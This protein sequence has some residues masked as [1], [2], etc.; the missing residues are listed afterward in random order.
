MGRPAPCALLLAAVLLL[1][2]PRAGAPRPRVTANFACR[3][4]ADSALPRPRCRQREQDGA[5]LSPPALALSTARLCQASRDCQPCVRVR[6]ALHTAGL[7]SV[8]GLQLDFLVLG[9]NR[10][11]WLKVWRKQPEAAGSLW[12]VQFDCFPV[13]SGR[14]V[15]VSLGTVPDRG[16]SLNR[17]HLVAAEPA[18]PKFSYAWRPE[19]RAIEVSVPEGPALAVRL[20]H[21]L[22]LECEELSTPFPRQALVSGGHSIVLPYEFLVPCLCIEASYQHRDSLRTKLCPF[23]PQPEAYG[24]EL[25]ASMQFHDYSAS[26]EANMVMVLSARCPLHPTATLCWKESDTGAC[27]SVP[28][29]TAMESNQAYTVEKVDV[30]PLLC[31]KF[32]YGNSSHV[33][34]PHRPDTA[35]NVSVSIR[36]LQLLLRVTSTVPA[37]FSAALC[38]QQGSRCEPEAPVYTVT[39]PES[40]G[41]RE[42]TL[43]L[44]LQ[45]VGG[46]VLVWRSD[47]HFARKQLLCADVARKRFGL[48]ALGLGLALGLLGTVLLLNCRSLRK[49]TTAP[50]GRR[51]VLLVYSP[52]SEEHKVLVCTLADVLCSA[53]G[54]DVRLDLW[55]AGSVGR[56]GALPWLYVQRELVARE[57]GTVLILWSQGS[58]RLYQLWRGAAAGSSGSPDPHDLFGAAMSCLQSELQVGGGAGRLG[59]WALA[60][61]GELCSRRDVPPALCLLPCYHLPRELPGLACLL[62]GSA[63]PPAWLRPSTLLHGLLMSEKR[64]SLQGR[65]E[66]CRLQQPEGAPLARLAA[67]QV[68]SVG[69]SPRAPPAR[70]TSQRPS[71]T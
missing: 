51:P 69:P 46:C 15:L 7:G 39:S 27:H 33:E 22:A 64:K 18:G 41:P 54:C 12:Q 2:G 57:Q 34:C 59:D 38:R 36:F 17:S 49:L 3:V 63:R 62:Q 1:A 65:V 48:L 58:A 55:E 10:A 9:S 26:S 52:D 5:G 44:P 20:C 4:R 28:N 13:E 14:R 37:S 25:W 60:Y 68:G 67:H 53:L 45:I 16:L 31:F 61:F 11:S 29:S 50:R 71:C 70:P 6:L 8:C 66:L 47:V 35:W 43:P 40:F 56:L 24:S 23:Q 21:Q 19:A 32:S 42:L 30:H